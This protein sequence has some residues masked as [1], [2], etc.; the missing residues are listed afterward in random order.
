MIGVV[1][2]AHEHAAGGMLQAAE[3]VVGRQSLTAVLDVPKTM[4]PEQLRDR[5]RDCIASADAGDGVLVL[6]DMFGGTPCNIALE[7]LEPG[8]IEVVSGFNIPL[9]VKAFVMRREERDV[10]VLAREVVA[11]GRQYICL[12]SELIGERRSRGDA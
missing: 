9:L 6:V 10:T 4:P 11:S 12:A 8:R 1:L 5:M 2:V 7:F 3:H